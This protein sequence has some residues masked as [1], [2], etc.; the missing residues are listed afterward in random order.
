[1]KK[2]I[3]IRQILCGMYCAALVIQNVLATKTVDVAMFTVTT[4]VLMS[5]IVFILQDVSS[6]LYGYEKT[7]GMVLLSFFMNFVAVLMFQLAIM[8]PPSSSFANQAAFVATLGS[9]LRI[10]CA[11]FAAYLAGSLVNSKVMVE[12]KKNGDG[13]FTRAITSTVAGQFCDNAIFSFC[14]FAFVLP[15]PVIW[16]MVFGATL[17]EVVYE[18]IFYPVTK[19]AINLCNNIQ[20]KEKE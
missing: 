8:L 7:K 1:M 9:T 20:G 3:G 14:A 5:P 13:L 16:S 6:E 18:I 12:L 10:T 4:G 15:V 11:S 17:F 19:F 2:G